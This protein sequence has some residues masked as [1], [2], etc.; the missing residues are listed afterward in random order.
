MQFDRMKRRDFITLLGGAAAWPLAARAQQ[1]AMP[2]VGFLSSGSP[3]A[4]APYLD[5]FRLGLEQAGFV[6]G[7]NVAIVYRWARGRDD[8]L[9][10]LA[11]E[12]VERKVGV[13]A[14][15]GEPAVMAAKAA[16]ATTSIIFLID[17]DPV[18]LGLV[19]GFHRP[20]GNLSGVTMLTLALDLQRLALLREALPRAASIAVLI[21]PNFP[22]S[23]ARMREV[24][25]AARSMVQDLAL[26]PASNEGE[27]ERA[28]A[29]FEQRRPDALLVASDPFLDSRRDQI[30]ALAARYVVPA[31]YERRGFAAAGG[32]MS[33]GTQLAD[34]YRKQGAYT[35]LVLKETSP[36]DLPVLQP[37]RFELVIN[38]K[39]AKAL[40]LEIPPP[41]IARA[42]ALIE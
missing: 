36:A 34:L 21:N 5:A 3:E 23:P 32:L 26:A 33:Y 14:A 28:F 42:D 17:G 2:V 6:E 30:V 29:K 12:L 13:I 40:G 41:F 19:A 20:G 31:M 16:T 7:R 18:R 24:Q 10:A 25:D 22:G 8:Q 9:P 4:F 15:S 27:I 1:P 37:T 11:A 39:T 38:L 35:A